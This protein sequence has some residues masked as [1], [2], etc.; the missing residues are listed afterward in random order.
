MLNDNQRQKAI[1]WLNSRGRDFTAGVKILEASGF[2]PGVV[3]R[4]K[5]IGESESA[6]MH[7]VENIRLYLRFFGCE[8]EDTDAELGV[9]DGQQPE[10]LNQ[11]DEKKGLTLDK[12]AVKVEAGEMNVPESAGQ[13]IIEYAKLYRERE[14]AHREMAGVAESNDAEHVAARRTLSDTIDRLTTKME[15]LYPLVGG[16]LDNGMVP[17][18]EA[19]EAALADDEPKAAAAVSEAAGVPDLAELSKE[20]LQKRLK[21]AKTKI[22]RKSNLLEYQ[23]ETKAEVPNPLPECPKRVKYETEI[24]AL[25]EEVESL[26]YAIARKG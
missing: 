17:E 18:T 26:Q 14:M 15:K 20:E 24:A 9:F 16:F 22:L 4:L 5:S 2:K 21:S 19:V 25:K 8:I 23:R 11:E 10:E 7:L 13:A 6:K 12:L 3:R 1:D